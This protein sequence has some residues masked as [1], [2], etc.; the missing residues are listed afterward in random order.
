MKR[1]QNEQWINALPEEA[2]NIAEEINIGI[3]KVIAER[4]KSIGELTP[5]DIKKLNNSHK[6]LGA[7]FKKITKLIAKQSEQG[8][9]AVNK[10]IKQAAEGNDEFAKSLYAARGMGAY[11]WQNDLYLHRLVSAM[12]KQTG[13]QFT[14]LSQ[15][16]A[17]KINNQTIPLRQMY[18]R[19]ID[20]AIYEVQSGTI[21]YHTA[22]RK[23]VRELATELRVQNSS[24]V[25]DKKTGEVKLH[26]DS[27]HTKRLDSHVRQNLIDG[28]KQLQTEMLDYHGQQFG[29]DGVELSAHAICAPDHLAVQGRQ[30]SNDEFDKMQS[31]YDFKDVNDNKYNGF[32][33]PIGQWNCRHV[34]FPI[35]I[36]ISEPAHTDEQL[37][38]MKQ[39]SREKY[40]LTQMQRAMETKL[41]SLKNQ[42]LAASAAGD[43][44]EAKRL[45]RKINEE[46]TTY[47]RFSE[48]HDLLYDTRRASVEG[49]RRISIKGLQNLEN[50]DILKKKIAN[51]EIT[52]TINPEKQ[53]PHML[54]FR[55]EGSKKSYFT[56]TFEELQNILNTNYATGQVTISRS[57]QIKEIIFIN[58]N[59]GYDVDETGFEKETKGFKVHYSKNRTHL[60]PYRKRSQEDEII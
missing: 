55:K 36:G 54:K 49:Y 14:N 19:A 5:S 7:D 25:V 37:E 22:M 24:L 3:A 48:K 52:L 15:T 59:I 30:F 51:G 4:I 43:E 39:N 18:T 27:G 58:K 11:S 6:Y 8:Q 2:V 41:R 29:S 20:K 40:N 53:N 32:A 60:V 47:R 12:V 9:K 56:I 17:Y 26:W 21:D 44:L 1:I 10:A 42:R 33:R 34:R 23:T 45:Q 57:G 35:I 38:Q 31:G 50:R 16:L 13:A 46:Q 28:I